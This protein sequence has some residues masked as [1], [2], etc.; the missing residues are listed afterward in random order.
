MCQINNERKVG[1]LKF[2][3]CFYKKEN[4]SPVLIRLLSNNQKQNDES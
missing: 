2:L 4:S 3:D 1:H